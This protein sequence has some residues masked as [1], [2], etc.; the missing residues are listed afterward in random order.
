MSP[1]VQK[2]PIHMLA[3][4]SPDSQFVFSVQLVPLV[5][6]YRSIKAE[7]AR[8]PSITSG[9]ATGQPRLVSLSLRFTSASI[10]IGE[11]CHWIAHLDLV[12]RWTPTEPSFCQHLVEQPGQEKLGWR[13]R[14]KVQNLR[15]RERL[16]KCSRGRG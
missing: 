9:S 8:R 14:V 1:P 4:G 3:Q 15:V 5:A 13:V 2:T 6:E 10:P 12:V 11:P 16:R 7:T